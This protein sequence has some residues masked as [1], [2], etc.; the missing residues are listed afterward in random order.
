MYVF[1]WGR[2]V[3]PGGGALEVRLWMR[4]IVFLREIDV[5]DAGRLGP[6]ARA[7]DI[8]WVVRICQAGV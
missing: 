5:F 2:I 3:L 1:R 7:L 8:R 4:R 6:W